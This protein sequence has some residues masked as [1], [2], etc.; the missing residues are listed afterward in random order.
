MGF[1]ISERLYFLFFF[2]QNPIFSSFFWETG[3]V[4]PYS[5]LP[6]K[7]LYQGNRAI[8]AALNSQ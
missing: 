6:F 5:L 4:S 7:F 1:S 8:N 3:I 2:S